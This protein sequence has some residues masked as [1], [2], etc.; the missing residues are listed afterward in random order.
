MRVA[1]FGLGY[2]GTVTAACLAGEDRAVVGVDPDAGKVDIINRGCSPVVE[3]G[4][5]E[6]VATAV[7]EGWLEATSDVE[8]AL[9]GADIALLC[10]GTPSRMDGSGD[11]RFIE[12]ASEQ[13]GAYLKTATKRLAVVVR[14]TVPPGS[15]QG[16]VAPA[17]ERTSGLTVHADFDV[18]M[19]PEFLREGQGVADFFDPEL[20]VIGCESPMATT[21]IGSL[22]DHVPAEPIVTGIRT[23]EA[24]KYACN[25]YHAVKVSFTNEFGR[26]CQVMDVDT[27][28]VMRVFCEDKRLNISTAYLRPGFAFG[29]SCLPKDL[30]ALLHM[31]RVNSIDLPLLQGTEHTNELV[32][33]NVTREVLYTTHK[34]VAMLGLSFKPETDDLRESPYVELAETLI[35]KGLEI[36]IYDPV[37]RPERL[38]GGNLRYVDDHLPHLRRLLVDEPEAALT[39]A[40]VALVGS[41]SEQ[42]KRALLADPPPVLIDLVGSLGPEIEALP[43]Y[44]GVSW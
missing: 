15:V 30:R 16:V 12:R 17:I 18:A 9:D 25:A 6:I 19:C 38:V 43:G 11:L 14:S 32:V 33:R 23:A 13:I 2:V 31:A 22:F 44:R 34:R 27:R 42:V 24:I 10:V 3:P 36:Q 4:L 21:V 29:G 1:V 5:D 26:L 7:R 28:E 41:S 37:I 40:E 35:G 20:I 39:G 8:A